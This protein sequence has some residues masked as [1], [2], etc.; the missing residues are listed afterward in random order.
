MK[1]C[2]FTSLEEGSWLNKVFLKGRAALKR[3]WV[4]WGWACESVCMYELLSWPESCTL[5]KLP[6]FQYCV[7][8][9]DLDFIRRALTALTIHDCCNEQENC[10]WECPGEKCIGG[11]GRASLVLDYN[12]DLPLLQKSV[13][14]NI[15]ASWEQ[16]KI[17][18]QS[19]HLL[20][21]TEKGIGGRGADIFISFRSWAD[22][23]LNFY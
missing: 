22:R 16:C 14:A 17:H 8:L 18:Q 9:Q 4:Q 21:K 19:K 11:G 5:L 3:F 13:T 7:P 12:N 2:Y 6:L 15:K 20:V 1:I 23:F 10:C